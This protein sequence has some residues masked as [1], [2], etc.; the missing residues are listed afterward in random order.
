M[1][2]L[3]TASHSKLLAHYQ[4]NVDAAK[5]LIAVGERKADAALPPAELAA[6]TMLCNALLNLDEVLN[7]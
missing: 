3:I 5:A 4:G 7:K 1:A 6:M 2:P